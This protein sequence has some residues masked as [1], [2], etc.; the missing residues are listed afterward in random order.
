MHFQPVALCAFREIAQKLGPIS[1][2]PEK[3]FPSISARHNVVDC[4]S[5]LNPSR[6]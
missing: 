5:K 6:S 2:I 1:I 3:L 4:S